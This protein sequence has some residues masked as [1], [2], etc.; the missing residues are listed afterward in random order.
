MSDSR[1][2]LVRKIGAQ[3]CSPRTKISGGCVPYYSERNPPQPLQIRLAVPQTGELLVCG[4]LNAVSSSYETIIGDS[5]LTTTNIKSL[6]ATEFATGLIF[7]EGPRWHDGRLF[8]SDRL[9]GR[10]LS[11][12]SAGRQQIVA[13]VPNR[14]N[15]MA[16][17]PDGILLFTSMLDAKVYRLERGGPVCTRT[18][19]RLLPVT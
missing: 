9:A 11:F 5:N 1:G 10:I 13:D 6:R 7:G 2:P 16:F 3:F 8:I 19:L 18:L 15:G 4:Q 14:P 17:M 12:D